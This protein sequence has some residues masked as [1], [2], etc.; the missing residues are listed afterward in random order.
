MKLGVDKHGS[1][2]EKQNKTKS[3]TTWKE[4]KPSLETAY[5]VQQIL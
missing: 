4:N 2:R 5:N 1:G 3:V